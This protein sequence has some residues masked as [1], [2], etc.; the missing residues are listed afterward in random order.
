MK[1]KEEHLLVGD[2][3]EQPKPIEEQA[4]PS[5]AIPQE[6]VKT[7][8]AELSPEMLQKVITAAILE[9][10]CTQKKEQEDSVE[11]DTQS[12]QKGAFRGGIKDF[13]E[14]IKS[15]FILIFSKRKRL[16][17]IKADTDTLVHTA[18]MFFH[19]LATLAWYIVGIA[20]WLIV[21][22]R[23]LPNMG[24]TDGA[25]GR[26]QEAYRFI[27]TVDVDEV[28]VICIPMGF[29]ALA[30]GGLFRLV[31]DSLTHSKDMEKNERIMALDVTVITAF[32]TLIKIFFFN[33][34]AA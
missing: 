20:L 27:H 34:A 11:Q 7:P 25:V 1:Q 4:N 18:A 30:I 16:L 8:V 17:Q 3:A 15:A 5:V 33:G 24:V 19:T 32:F 13:W 6:T 9:A 12:G 14:G 2:M 21:V 29:V 10:N 28:L 22:V 26:L 31:S 23:L